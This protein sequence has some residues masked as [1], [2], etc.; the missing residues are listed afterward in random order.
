MVGFK[1]PVGKRIL[2]EGRRVDS[3]LGDVWVEEE[4]IGNDR[5][6]DASSGPVCEV[7]WRRMRVVLWVCGEFGL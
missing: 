7:P 3:V 5:R 4:G 6:V 2:V 1:A